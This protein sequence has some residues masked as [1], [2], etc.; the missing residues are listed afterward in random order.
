MLGSRNTTRL[1]VVQ[2]YSVSIAKVLPLTQA[3][4]CGGGGS[5][6]TE[7][8]QQLNLQEGRLR[9]I[10][11][12]QGSKSFPWPNLILWVPIASI[13]HFFCATQGIFPIYIQSK[14]EMLATLM[15]PTARYKIDPMPFL[16]FSAASFGQH[17]LL[18]S[19][20]R[21]RPVSSFH[22]H[23]SYITPSSLFDTFV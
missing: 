2:L 4:S 1:H 17:F 3:L 14:T 19:Y 11:E 13:M 20:S 16:S 18:L 22:A 6:T 21:Q 7:L 15:I 23:P 5:E 8:G 9:A 12:R 10:R